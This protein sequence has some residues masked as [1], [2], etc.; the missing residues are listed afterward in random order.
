V[1][2]WIIFQN[3][4]HI[5]QNGFAEVILSFRTRKLSFLKK[6][7][8]CPKFFRPEGTKPKKLRQAFWRPENWE[9]RLTL[10][11]E[12]E[13]FLEMHQTSLIVDLCAGLIQPDPKIWREG[14]YAF[15]AKIAL[16]HWFPL[17]SFENS[18]A[19]QV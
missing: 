6:T 7:K 10:M 8:A 13:T 9:A 15:K 12:S 19:N 3:I 1:I 2:K 18:S 11:F 4:I 5:I 16:H 17:C 14:F